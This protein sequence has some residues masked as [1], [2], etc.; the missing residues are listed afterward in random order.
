MAQRQ[1]LSLFSETEFQQVAGGQFPVICPTLD[2]S[3]TWEDGGKNLMIYRP[4]RQS[5]SKIHQL[6]TPGAT[7]PE[8]LAVTWKPDGERTTRLPNIWFC[9]LTHLS[10]NFLAV[11]W[12]DGAVRLMGLESNKVAHHIK[13]CEK[14]D[15]KITHIGCAM[16]AATCG[17]STNA[18]LASVESNLMENLSLDGV[19]EV[20]SLPREL[21]FLEVDSALPKISP[22]PSSSAGPG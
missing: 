19:E 4:P 15:V 13:V 18:P 17:S 22:L 8:P 10:G 1:Q 5:V 20:A 2:L 9:L 21:M 7:A 3:A 16:S 14:Q 11:G 6:G 12:S